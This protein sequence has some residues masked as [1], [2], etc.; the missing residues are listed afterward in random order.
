MKCLGLFVNVQI[1]IV[2]TSNITN[3]VTFSPKIAGVTSVYVLSGGQT[4]TVQAKRESLGN[5][6]NG[7][8]CRSMLRI[9]VCVTQPKQHGHSPLAQG[10]LI[11]IISKLDQLKHNSA[12]IW[13][14]KE[15]ICNRVILNRYKNTSKM[16]IF[17]QKFWGVIFWSWNINIMFFFKK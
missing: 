17:E 13:P 16:K 6:M 11:L 12:K 5:R 3:N 8:C 15:N 2:I 9:C 14:F 7:G 4:K 10:N 1:S